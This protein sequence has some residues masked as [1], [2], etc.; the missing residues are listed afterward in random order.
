MSV[1]LTKTISNTIQNKMINNN[2]FM[3]NNL[4]LIDNKFKDSYY[5]IKVNKFYKKIK[6]I[7]KN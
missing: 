4:K 1:K 2:N 5:K 7:I 6:L 3:N